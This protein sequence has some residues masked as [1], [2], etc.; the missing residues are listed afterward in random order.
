MKKYILPALIAIV[1]IG[2]TVYATQQKTA[3]AAKQ[4][5]S[6]YNICLLLDLSDRID[7]RK[8]PLQAEKDR[9]VI[10]AV[11][12]EF[13]EI[14]KKGL[15]VNSR[16][17]LR[18]AVAPQPTDYRKTL[19]EL[20]DKLAIDMRELKVT[21]KRQKLPELKE[22]FIAH[23][24]TLYDAAVKNH[25]FTGGDIW[26]FFRDNLESYRVQGSETRPVRNI[27]IVLTDGYINFA[28]TKGRPKEESR[29]SWMEVSRLRHNG[30]E[31][32]FD[33]GD[34]GMIPAGKDHGSWEVLV[35]E[36]NPKSPQDLPIIHKYWSKWF[37]EMGISHYRIA[38]E[39]DSTTLTKEVIST[40]I[41]ESAH[42][43]KETVVKR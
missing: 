38:K 39:S 23:S 27:L 24:G 18:V 32:E 30:W 1:V 22:R 37:E 16:D 13:T 15:Y 25:Q 9:K 6:Q 36:V 19:L 21:E 43:E 42:P 17:T 11:T 7:P 34:G 2:T 20:G 5:G 8:V 10:A 29:T 40:F 33:A 35:L 14:V 41:K 26:S 12:E 4:H 31:E 3:P 28:S